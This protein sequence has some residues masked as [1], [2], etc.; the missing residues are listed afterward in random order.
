MNYEILIVDDQVDAADEYRR[1]VYSKTK[2]STCSTSDPLEA[3]E[4]TRNNP[5]KIAILDQKMPNKKGTDLFAEIREINPLI[6]AIML[7]GEADT[8]EVAKALSLGYSDY[9]HKS[10]ISKLPNRIF[11]YYAQCQN[12][13][14]TNQIDNKPLVLF[15]ENR[16]G[17]FL[18]HQIEFKLISLELLDDEFILPNTWETI[19]LINSGE[20][21]SYTYTFDATKKI[22]IEGEEQNIISAKLGLTV[23]GVLKFSDNLEGSI[24]QKFH[25]QIIEESKK[26]ISVNREYQLPVDNTNNSKYV[27]SRRFERA[28]VYRK[29]RATVGV[30]CDCCKM[31]KYHFFNVLQLTNNVA[32]R[33]VDYF[34]DNTQNTVNTGIGY[35]IN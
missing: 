15:K 33:Q 35:S 32:T 9:I 12:E 13:I 18:S 29:I 31:T 24:N 27:K 20:K 34:S 1:F 19:L 30:Y 5:I 4:I 14:A 3:L 6:K 28:K 17:W 7:T 23:E 16:G 2:I 25:H 21:Q 26:T 22:L 8:E 11:Y 10:D